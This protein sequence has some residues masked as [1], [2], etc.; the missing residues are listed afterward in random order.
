M[1]LLK[2]LFNITLLIG[3]AFSASGCSEMHFYKVEQSVRPLA[4]NAFRT[5]QPALASRGTGCIM[6]HSNIGSNIITDFGYG[7]DGRG[8]NYFFGG[9]PSVL[10]F[11]LH[12][13]KGN[14]V[15]GDFD[16][17]TGSNKNW[18]SATLTGK[19]ITV[20]RA[21]TS[22]VDVSEPT[23]AAYLKFILANSDVEV[24]KAVQVK[25]VS[26]VYIGAPTAD[27]IRAVANLSGGETLKYIPTHSDS[28]A[29]SGIQ[30][31]TLGGYFTNANI[32]TCEG[33]VIIDGI[34]WLNN[35]QINTE[36]G[37]HLYVTKS[38]FISGPVTFTTTN[39]SRNLQISSARAIALG[40]GRNTCASTISGLDS[41][42]YRLGFANASI[43]TGFFT[44]NLGTPTEGIVSIK[45]DAD[46]IG[47]LKD[48]VCEPLGRNVGFERL[49]LN[50]PVV[51]SRYKGKFSGSIIAEITLASLGSLIFTFDPVLARVPILP[52]LSP[53]DYLTVQ[54]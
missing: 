45:A 3:S 52:L 37:C 35:A 30:L 42:A 43:F 5:I 17:T 46:T 9:T 38:V 34:L 2:H 6:C 22:D 14:S 54:D 39:D 11:G 27:R 41:I 13:T 51:H 8:L 32:I 48:A 36:K 47:V 31:S 15:Y 18:A 21:P 24:S 44:R 28:P 20:P 40:L 7:G 19:T 50:A 49:L 10:P 29:L 26:S 53:S 4:F 16:L 33:E 12:N 25:E 23:L 1:A